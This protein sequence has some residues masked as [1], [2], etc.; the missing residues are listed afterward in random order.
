MHARRRR[1]SLEVVRYR[2]V[3]FRA[4]TEPTIPCPITDPRAASP[5]PQGVNLPPFSPL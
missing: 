3:P 1:N 4:G 2:D 5:Q